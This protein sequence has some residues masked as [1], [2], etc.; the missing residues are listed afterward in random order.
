[1]FHNIFSRLKHKSKTKNK[2]LPKIFAD[3]HE[4]DSMILAELKNN[5]D[6]ELIVKPLKIADYLIGKTAIER[7]TT[8]DFISSMLSKRLIEQLYHMNRYK[9]K[10]LIIEG[11]IED[12][13]PKKE[14]S[15][16]NPNAIRGF[17]LSIMNNH[18]TKIIFTI[19]YK[20]TSDYLITLTKQQLKSKTEISLHSRIPRTLKEQKR[21]ILESFPNIGPKKA[22]KLLKKFPNLLSIFNADEEELRE[23][24]KN[25]SGEF[26]YILKE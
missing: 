3:I 24:L 26:K 18:D 25:R 20:D 23:I 5:K 21:Y 1:M 16:L 8:N 2:I 17:I 11:K 4:K 9:D 10:I 22:E 19:D 7:K 12:L 14:Q 15:K 6:I 13:Y